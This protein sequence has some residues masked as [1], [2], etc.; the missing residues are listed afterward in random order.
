MTYTSTSEFIKSHIRYQQ[1]WNTKVIDMTKAKWQS[2][3]DDTYLDGTIYA[4]GSEFK[5]FETT[6]FGW[7]FFSPDTKTADGCIPHRRIL[8][9]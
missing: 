8:K 6:N 2:L 4:K 5:V 7:I 1:H 9:C 3:S